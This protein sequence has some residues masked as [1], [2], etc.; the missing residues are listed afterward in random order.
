MWSCFSRSI[1]AGISVNEWDKHV[2]GGQAKD[3]RRYN[4]APMRAAWEVSAWSGMREMKKSIPI[5]LVKYEGR[6]KTIKS[7][8]WEEE[9]EIEA[10][11]DQSIEAKSCC[12]TQ[13][14]EGRQGG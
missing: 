11:A 7:E 1:V 14:V 4:P 3:I 6:A 12:E 5:W 9:S 2:G 13:E 10:T 8:V